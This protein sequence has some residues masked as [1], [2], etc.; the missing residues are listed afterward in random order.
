MSVVCVLCVCVLVMGG[1]R[2][3]GKVR[4]SDWH[5]P[6]VMG[7]AGDRYRQKRRAGISDSIVASQSRIATHRVQCTSVTHQLSAAFI[8][9][10]V[11]AKEG[12]CAVGASV[13]QAAC[14]STGILA[15]IRL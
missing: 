11:S 1:V 3:R 7:G 2:G 9:V 10:S 15:H 13:M 4:Q 6:H 5:L 12:M 8:C 14:Q